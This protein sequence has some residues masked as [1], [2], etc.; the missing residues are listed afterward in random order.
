MAKN[1][2]QEAYEKALVTSLARVIDLVKF[3]EA[4]NAA[5]LAFTSAWT[6][7]AAN[8][9]ARESVS[10]LAFI[11]VLPVSGSLFLIAALIA[12]Y[13]ILPRVKLAD[14]FKGEQRISRDLNLLFYGDISEVDIMNYPER[15]RARYL[16][17]EKQSATD[18][19]LSDLSCQ[20]HVNSTIANR[21]Y[22][23]F[24]MG[25]WISLLSMAVLASPAIWYLM[26]G[27]IKFLIAVAA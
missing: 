19:Y 20:I 16:P 2:Q 3:A 9:M 25:A 18:Q 6:V 14:F 24:K 7:A 21:K 1:D 5:L 15:L 27:M 23:L 13:S 17:D 4:K 11:N 12:L 8:L 26:R 10:P 22:S